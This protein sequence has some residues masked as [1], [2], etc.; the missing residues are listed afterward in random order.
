MAQDELFLFYFVL[1]KYN[2]K[3]S[4]GPLGKLSTSRRNCEFTKDSNCTF[5]SS[6]SDCKEKLKFKW[7]VIYSYSTYG[8]YFIHLLIYI[9]TESKAF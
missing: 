4:N 6:L 5:F 8:C 2:K 3:N 7:K 9:L 1:F